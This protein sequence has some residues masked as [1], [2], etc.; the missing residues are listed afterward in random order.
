M[1][2]KLYSILE[3]GSCEIYIN[4]RGEG[5]LHVYIRRTPN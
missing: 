1:F 2:N 4:V 3:A 5:I